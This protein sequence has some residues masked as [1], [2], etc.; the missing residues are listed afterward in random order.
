MRIARRIP[1]VAGLLVLLALLTFALPIREWR[2]GEVASPPLPVVDGGP[3]VAIPPRIWIDTDAACGAGRT[4]DPDDCFAIVLLA[5]APEVDLVGIST[6]AGNASLDVTDSTTR[7]LIA[8]IARSGR[9]VPV[10]RGPASAP[11]LVKALDQGPLTVVALG[12]LTNLDAV[13]HGRPELR[14]NVGRLV[15]VMGRRPGHLFH[16]AE[17]KGKGGILFGHGPVFSDFNFEQDRVAA[18]RVLNMRLPTTFL[19]YDAARQLMLT[20]RDL[21]R[22]QPAGGAAAWVAEQSRDWLDYW[23]DDIG[24]A[25][26]Y[27]FD[28]LAAAYVVAPQQFGC[29]PAEAAIARDLRLWGRLWGPWGVLVNRAGVRPVNAAAHAPVLYCERVRPALHEWLIEQLA[30][31]V[32]SGAP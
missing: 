19:P 15:A 28:L 10:Y 27:P 14:A 24:V 9:A 1:V 11:P 22:L 32:Q 3:R 21:S 31:P 26:F 2:T 7:A 25:G 30:T 8:Q 20:E 23:K 17:G 5:L 18:I 29:A 4:T 13:L 12:P 16:P 6:V